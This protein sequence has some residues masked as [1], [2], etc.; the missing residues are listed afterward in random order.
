MTTTVTINSPDGS[1]A[2]GGNTIADRTTAVLN[3]TLIS[4][5]GVS[6]AAPF[7]LEPKIVKRNSA[8][9][10]DIVYENQTYSHGGTG[11]EDMTLSIPFQVPATGTYYLACYLASGTISVKTSA[12]RAQAAGDTTGVGQ[13]MTEGTAQVYA[14]RYTYIVSYVLTSNAGAF[15]ETG[16]AALRR[17]NRQM[18]FAAFTLTGM[19]VPRAYGRVSA[20]GSFALTGIAAILHRL[21][22]PAN[23]FKNRVANFVLQKLRVTPPTLS[24]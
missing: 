2:V 5:I 10:Y 9:N 14:L 17:I 3:N 24:D 1:A 16:L 8:G 7:T 22:A 13:A 4:K 11:F 6:S 20:A 12:S 21:A 19:A 23:K 15:V 18:L